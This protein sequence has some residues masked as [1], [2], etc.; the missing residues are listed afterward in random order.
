MSSLRQATGEKQ[1]AP[2]PD[3]NYPLN[4]SEQQKITKTVKRNKIEF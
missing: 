1:A 3:F 2:K 4:Q